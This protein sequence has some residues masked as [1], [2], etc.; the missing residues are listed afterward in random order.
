[1]APVIP[2]GVEAPVIPDGVVAP[3]VP[4]GVE[5]PLVT[6]SVGVSV[7]GSGSENHHQASKFPAQRTRRRNHVW[8]LDM[9]LALTFSS[10]C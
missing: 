8:I 4:G 7:V 1:M 10:T 5:A 6:A 2:G 3:V 9:L